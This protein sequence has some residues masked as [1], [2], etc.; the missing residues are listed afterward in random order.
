MKRVR[1]S[2]LPALGLAGALAFSGVMFAQTP[3]QRPQQQPGQ[4]PSTHPGQQ[5]GTEPGTEMHHGTMQNQVKTYTG[6]VNK[7]G[8]T[9]VLELPSQKTYY[10]LS[11][12]KKAESFEGKNVKVTGSLDAATN[13]INVQ[14]IE[15]AG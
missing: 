7:K 10:I 13:T 3:Q 12:Q 2:I 11:D 5:P 4:Q 14:T 6:K 9:Y 1:F 15:S 8:S